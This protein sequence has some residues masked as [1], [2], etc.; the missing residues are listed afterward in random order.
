MRDTELYRHILGIE[1]PW[2][3]S[4]VE[5]SMEKQRVDVWAEHKASASFTCPECEGAAGLHDHAEERVWRHLDTCQLSTY[6][7]ARVPRVNCPKHG[8]RQ[9]SVSWAEARSRF[10]LLFERF[11]IDVLRET[12]VDGVAKIL[13]LSWDEA[14]HLMERAVSRG[15]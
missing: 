8:V 4:K 6:L 13:G 14:H 7:H 11:A 3:V 15:L 5:L 1:S 10:T 2:T 9:V 12:D